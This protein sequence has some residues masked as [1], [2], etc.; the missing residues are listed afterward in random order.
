MVHRELTLGKMS[1]QQ[2]GNIVGSGH[3]R[4]RALGIAVLAYTFSHSQLDTH[5]IRPPDA[6]VVIIHLLPL[7]G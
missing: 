1:R 6:V 4:H 3:C 5:A 7:S 2:R